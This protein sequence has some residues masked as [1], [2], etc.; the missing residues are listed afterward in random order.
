MSLLCRCSGDLRGNEG[1]A[2][3]EYSLMLGRN[4]G[5]L[6][7]LAEV[8]PFLV[9]KF[10]SR[11]FLRHR[12]SEYSSALATLFVQLHLIPCKCIHSF[13]GPHRVMSVGIAMLFCLL[14]TSQI[15]EYLTRRNLYLCL[16][17]Y[18]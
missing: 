11:P 13:S 4:G 2:G 18:K 17:C 5:T 7:D 6:E 8:K 16:Y 12:L 14:G 10:L 1:S 15:L 9:A 3:R